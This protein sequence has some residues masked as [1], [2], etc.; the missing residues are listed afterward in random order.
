MWR[1]D[2]IA[3][4]INR[5]PSLIPI[6]AAAKA[7]AGRETS[8]VWTEVVTPLRDAMRLVDDKSRDRDVGQQL[9]TCIGC[10]SLRRHVAQSQGPAPCGLDDG[11]LRG[12]IEHRMKRACGYAA[13]VQVV[14]L[15]F[16]QRDER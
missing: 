9:R 3:S 8:I 15:I 14:D 16:H 4:S 5:R 1:N 13:P 2:T 12:G 6:G 10:E 11:A 7:G